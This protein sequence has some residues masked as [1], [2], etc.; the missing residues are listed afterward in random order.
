MASE[1]TAP[2]TGLVVDPGIDPIL[3]VPAAA[4]L[5]GVSFPVAMDLVRDGRLK[6]AR[7]GNGRGQWR[8]R[9]SWI[10][11]YMD[12]VAGGALTSP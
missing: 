8:I 3:T 7:V 9:R 12:T 6:A 5:L 11:A 10:Y 2:A 4:E 1:I